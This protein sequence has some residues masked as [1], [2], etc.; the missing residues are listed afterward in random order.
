MSTTANRTFTSRRLIT[1]PTIINTITIIQRHT[2]RLQ[3]NRSH[4]IIN[5]PNNHRRIIRT[6][7][8]QNSITRRIQRINILIIINI[9]TTSTNRRRLPHRLRQRTLTRR[10]H[11]RRRLTTRPQRNHTTLI[12]PLPQ[13]A[14]NNPRQLMNIIRMTIIHNITIITRRRL[15]LPHSILNSTRTL[16]RHTLREV[17]INTNRRHIRNITTIIPP[18]FKTSH[19]SHLSTNITSRMKRCQLSNLR[20]ILT[21]RQSIRQRILIQIQNRRSIHRPPTPTNTHIQIHTQHLPRSHL[22]KIQMRLH[23]CQRHTNIMINRIRQPR[24]QPSINSSHNTTLIRRLHRQNRPQIRTMTTTTLTSQHHNT[25]LR[26]QRRINQK[27]TRIT[28]I[29]LPTTQPNTNTTTQIL[30]L[31][32]HQPISQS[33]HTRT[34]MTTMRMRTSRHTVIILK[35]TRRPHNTINR[36]RLQRRKRRTPQRHN[37]SRQNLRRV[38]AARPTRLASPPDVQTAPTSTATHPTHKYSTSQPQTTD[39]KETHP[40]RTTATTKATHTASYHQ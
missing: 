14:M 12:R 24:R 13:R 15:R 32:P 2:T 28:Q 5:R 4:R 34:I 22:I 37:T 19:T 36:H 1:T 31:H 33:S 3:N 23:Q 8:T 9:R 16:H 6:T 35:P 25:I 38:T 20:R 39:Y 11:S 21:I 10:T 40:Q 30:M 7:S 26:R 18:Q 29:L 27:S 17:P